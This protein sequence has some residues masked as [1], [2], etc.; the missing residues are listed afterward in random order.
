ME[1]ISN[2]LYPLRILPIQFAV[3]LRLHIIKLTNRRTYKTHLRT[4]RDF[5]ARIDPFVNCD[6][7]RELVHDPKIFTIENVTVIALDRLEDIMIQR[8]KIHASRNFVGR[9]IIV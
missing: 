1:N 3:C 4:I 8:P 6:D 9:I 7:G 5:K 2:K